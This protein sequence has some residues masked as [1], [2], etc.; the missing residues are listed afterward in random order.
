MFDGNRGCY[1]F[2]RIFI[3]D[4]DDDDD[5]DTTDKPML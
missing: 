5:D 1:A 2:F 3:D 4:D